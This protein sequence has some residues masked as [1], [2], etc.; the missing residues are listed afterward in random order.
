MQIESA[1]ELKNIT[2]TINSLEITSSDLDNIVAEAKKLK[3]K[4]KGLVTKN[5]IVID[6]SAIEIKNVSF[7]YEVY[8]AFKNEDFKIIGIK[9]IKEKHKKNIQE[10]SDIAVFLGSNKKDSL[11][12]PDKNIEKPDVE[13][14][15]E[16][17]VLSNE[18]TK[19]INEV[20]RNGQKINHSGD[21]FIFSKVS[22]GAEIYSTRSVF[23]SNVAEGKIFAGIDFNGDGNGDSGAIIFIERFNANLICINGVYKQFENI[24]EKF[25]NK[26]VK[27]SLEGENLKIEL[28]EY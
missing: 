9:N 11:S 7:I 4:I 16:V 27:I 19:I 24:E 20:I 21:I 5:P 1:F 8:N 12:E 17:E 23:I 18:N 15:K 25:L 14:E 26:K 13:H 28:L 22:S 3:K 10:N 2:T 6:F